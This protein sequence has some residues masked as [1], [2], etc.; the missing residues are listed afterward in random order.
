MNCWFS[1]SKSSRVKI[2]RTTPKLWN[3]WGWEFCGWGTRAWVWQGS[4]VKA[5]SG[6]SCIRPPSGVHLGHRGRTRC[7][8][9]LRWSVNFCIQMNCRGRLPA[10]H[11]TQRFSAWGL[12]ALCDGG[13]PH[14]PECRP[15]PQRTCTREAPPGRQLQIWTPCWQNLVLPWNWRPS[16]NLTST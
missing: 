5:I 16:I 7:F 6:P 11:C 4:V 2:S 10:Q 14:T 8:P 9:S 15:Y 13:Q 12:S 1:A 3:P